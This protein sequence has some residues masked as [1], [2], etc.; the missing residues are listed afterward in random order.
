[1]K[2]KHLAAAVALAAAGTS[3]QAAPVPT[4]G[5]FIS[6]VDNANGSSFFGNLGVTTGTFLSTYANSSFTATGDLITDLS[7]WL[8]PKSDLTQIQWNIL[9]T[10]GGATIAG[11]G[12]LTTVSA[13]NAVTDTR[14]GE[15]NADLG[16]IGSFVEQRNLDLASSDGVAYTQVN[17]IQDFGSPGGLGIDSNA[18]LGAS[19]A[20]YELVKGTRTVQGEINPLAGSWSFNFGSGAAS[21]VYNAATAPVPVPAAVW[22]LGS[23]LLGMAGISR[24]K[25]S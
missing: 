3:V 16:N 7:A 1:M 11:T 24:R 12:G 20:F 4:D 9:G 14:T 6:I 15:F 10:I 25:Q 19:L 2:L 17:F 22:L 23:A 13:I 18:G 21:V 8:G 5:L